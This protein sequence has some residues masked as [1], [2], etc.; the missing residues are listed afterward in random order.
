M[1]EPLPI[2]LTSSFQH[3]QVAA[4]AENPVSKVVKDAQ[5][6]AEVSNHK[7][8]RICM[9]TRFHVKG[10]Y[11]TSSSQDFGDAIQSNAEDTAEATEAAY[12]EPNPVG[13]D[14]E[15]PTDTY[16]A[17]QLKDSDRKYAPKSDPTDLGA[18]KSP[19]EA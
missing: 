3:V 12:Q 5:K 15:Q 8:C 1:D 14:E 7:L 19:N 6:A 17:T 4:M 11:Q 13:Q 18:K 16:R 10:T 2:R 9:Q